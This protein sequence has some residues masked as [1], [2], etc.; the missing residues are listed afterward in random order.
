[1]SLQAGRTRLVT[2]TKDLMLNW[3]QT[4]QHWRDTRSEEF[5]RSYLAA[6]LPAVE[7]A[8]GAIGE[9]GVVLARIRHE[10]E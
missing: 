3:E 1:M 2:A 6:L 4:R 10:C 8:A 5:E 7:R 9:L